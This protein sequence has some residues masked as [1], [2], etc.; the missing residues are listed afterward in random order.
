VGVTPRA[1]DDVEIV[2]GE[3]ATNAVTHARTADGYRVELEYHPASRVVVTVADRGAG[4]PEDEP[5]P[6][7]T[8][9]PGVWGDDEGRIG[10]W[11]LPLARSLTERLEILPNE[12]QGTVVRAVKRLA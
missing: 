12:P 9:R 2:L 10:G 1:A 8:L 3:L 11:G 4:F 5:L 6:A 7:G